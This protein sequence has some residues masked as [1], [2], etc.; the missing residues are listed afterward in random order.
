MMDF[1][2]NPEPSR[3]AQWLMVIAVFLFLA[4]MFFDDR[5]GPN[6]YKTAG[7]DAAA[8]AKTATPPTMPAMPHGLS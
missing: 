7:A 3:A 8:A 1:P 4:Y 6:P 2:E 5:S